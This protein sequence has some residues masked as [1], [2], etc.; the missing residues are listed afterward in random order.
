MEIAA[1]YYSFLEAML[2]RRALVALVCVAAI[3]AVSIGTASAF[4]D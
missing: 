4:P 1:V 3:G 2:V